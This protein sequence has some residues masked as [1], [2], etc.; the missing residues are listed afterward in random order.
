MQRAGSPHSY[1]QRGPRKSGLSAIYECQWELL[2]PVKALQKSQEM[3]LRVK[4]CSA[5]ASATARLQQKASKVT[6]E[7]GVKC[8]KARRL[9]CAARACQ[10]PTAQADKLSDATDGP[11]V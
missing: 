6:A 1:C 11:P 2:T 4:V 5:S 10:L 9:R 3:Q 7:V 8:L